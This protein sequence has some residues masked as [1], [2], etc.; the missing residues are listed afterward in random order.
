M[1][2]MSEVTFDLFCENLE[3]K[4]KIIYGLKVGTTFPTAVSVTSNKL[5]SSRLRY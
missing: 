2:T 3:N 5:D 1:C 4:K